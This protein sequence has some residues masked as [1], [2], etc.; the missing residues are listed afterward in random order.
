MK[1]FQ[2]VPKEEVD[3]DDRLT[4][5]YGSKLLGLYSAL[6]PVVEGEEYPVKPALPLLLWLENDAKDY[7]DAD[8]K[9]MIFGRE[10]NNW[11][12]DDKDC[13]KMQ[14]G[15]DLNNSEDIRGEVLSIQSIYEGFFQKGARQRTQFIN[16][17]IKRFMNQLRTRFPN[18]TIESVWNNISKIGNSK[19]AHGKSSGRP[20]NYIREIENKYFNVVKDEIEIL[21]PDIILFLGSGKEYICEKLGEENVEF[22]EI[23]RGYVEIDRVL[24]KGVPSAYWISKH[25]CA[26]EKDITSI[27]DSCYKIVIDDI[28]KNLK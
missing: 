12:S 24:I 17:G 5:L 19:A 14:Y 22:K 18:R 15:F 8:L 27:M 28:E 20:A 11:N 1:E 3:L 7:T 26:R 4:N 21:Q 23:A 25:P 9:V 6:Q 2:Y 10:T 13:Y 16:R